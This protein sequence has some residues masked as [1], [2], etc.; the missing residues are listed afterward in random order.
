MNHDIKVAQ[1]SHVFKIIALLL[2][3]ITT[4]DINDSHFSLNSVFKR[5]FTLIVRIFF[6]DI[7][8]LISKHNCLTAH[9]Y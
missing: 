1:M 4:T 5:R 9:D 6:F 8:N 3:R 7:I 2:G